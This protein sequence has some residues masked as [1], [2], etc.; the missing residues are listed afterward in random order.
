MGFLWNLS[1]IYGATW[2]FHWWFDDLIGFF[3]DFIYFSWGLKKLSWDVA[4]MWLWFSSSKGSIFFLEISSNGDSLSHAGTPHHPS[5][6]WPLKPIETH[7]GHGD[8]GTV[9]RILRKPHMP[10][11]PT[12]FV[13]WGFFWD[14]LRPSSSI[15]WCSN[16]HH[17]F[18]PRFFAHLENT[19]G[20]FQS[21][22]GTPSSHRCF[23]RIFHW[24]HPGIGDPPWLNS[25]SLLVSCVVPGQNLHRS[26]PTSKTRRR[27]WGGD[28]FWI[29]ASKWRA[30]A[31]TCWFN[32]I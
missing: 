3:V 1:E 30:K 10:G 20:S 15:L 13:G 6:E 5:H 19:S 28:V 23:F 24:N 2:W 18:F 22:R 8:L 9:S 29:S 16:D 32:G 27:R 25:D 21:M 17:H 11:F 4:G 26:I 12:S 31:A 7:D 14:I